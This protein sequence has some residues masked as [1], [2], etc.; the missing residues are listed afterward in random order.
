MSCLQIGI[1]SPVTKDSAGSKF[2]AQLARQLSDFALSMMKRLGPIITLPDLYC[3][4][5]RARG[6]EMISPDDLYR[7]CELLADLRLPIQLHR[8]SSGVLVVRA[9]SLDD[10]E[11]S[12]EILKLLQENGPLTPLDLSHLKKISLALAKEQC[13]IAEQMEMVVRD[14][15]FEG[16][17]FLP[18]FTQRRSSQTASSFILSLFLLP[19]VSCH[20]VCLF[21]LCLSSNTK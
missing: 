15:T 5:N 11:I 2:H 4:Y 7:A 16:L 17:T 19:H 6:T 13:Q 10:S 12:K 3:L 21:V 14:E 20:V 18:Q 8:F 9:A 1:A